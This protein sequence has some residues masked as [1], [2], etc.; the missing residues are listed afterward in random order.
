MPNTSTRTPRITDLALALNSKGA[1][2]EAIEILRSLIEKITLNPDDEAQ[3]GHHIE[4]YGE[5][6]A[7]LKLGNQPVGKKANT[8]SKAAGVLQVTVVAGA[9]FEPAA[10]RL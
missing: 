1:R 3:N 4:V 8:R 5:I 6:G 7:I 10:F 2:E 9:G